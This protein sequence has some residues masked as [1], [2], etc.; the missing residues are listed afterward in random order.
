VSGGPEL[1]PEDVQEIL[2]LIDESPYEHFELETERFTIRVGDRGKTETAPAAAGLLDVT[3]P[4]VGVFYRA[5]GPGEEPFVGVGSHVE[6]E[7][8]VCVIEVMKLMNA[9]PAGVGGV[10]AEICADNGV[11]VQYGDVLFRIRPD[12]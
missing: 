5:P 3:S 11:S 12:A 1:T 2:R 7:T 6:A 10:V 9:V 4:M 8:Q